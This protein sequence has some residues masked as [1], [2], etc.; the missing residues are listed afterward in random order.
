MDLF[1]MIFGDTD[2]IPQE[3]QILPLLE[4]KKDDPNRPRIFLG[5]G[6]DDFLY[7]DST[8]FREKMETLD[9]DFT[10]WESE[11]EHNWVFWDACIQYALK[12][13]FG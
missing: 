2:E 5:V 1:H 6:R 7:D 4:E 8:A 12:W 3:E 9:Y 11:G 10:Y 13:M